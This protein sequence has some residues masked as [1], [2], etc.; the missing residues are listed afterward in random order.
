MMSSSSPPSIPA[1]LAF[2]AVETSLSDPPSATPFPVTLTLAATATPS[3]WES[4]SAVIAAV[5]VISSRPLPPPIPVAAASAVVV[6]LLSAW[7]S[8]V[9]F[10]LPVMS[11][12][13][14]TPSALASTWS[15]NSSCFIRVIDPSLVIVSS[16]SPPSMPVAVDLAV[17]LASLIA[18][19][20]ASPTM[21]PDTFKAAAM[22]SALD[23]GKIFMAPVLAIVSLLPPPS[24]PVALASA[25][26]LALLAAAPLTSPAA[27]P[28]M[29][30]LPEIFRDADTPRALASTSSTPRS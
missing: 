24:I 20:S 17:T 23:D 15:S 1:A 29:A 8:A 25:V 19:P 9:P 11:R 14:A 12:D 16:P 2:A 26:T 21:L 7:P 3:A 28:L 4:T 27:T 13:A 18:D 5:L 22:P 10:R 6:A 30:T